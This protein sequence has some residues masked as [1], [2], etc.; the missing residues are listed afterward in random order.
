MDNSKIQIAPEVLTWTQGVIMD[1]CPICRHWYPAFGPTHHCQPLPTPSPGTAAVPPQ[2]PAPVLTNSDAQTPP[3]H[4][5]VPP[6]PTATGLTKALDPRC[7]GCANCLIWAD[8][9]ICNRPGGPQPTMDHPDPGNPTLPTCQSF[10]R[11][12]ARLCS[13]Q[14]YLTLVQ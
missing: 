8:L 10:S 4:P 6:R 7:Q 1:L 11:G 14:E 9:L 13:Y 5:P 3:R 12:L 2:A